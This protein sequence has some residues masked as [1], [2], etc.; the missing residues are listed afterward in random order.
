MR[1]NVGFLLL[2][3]MMIILYSM[4]FA[5]D[6]EVAENGR[7]MFIE[8]RCYTC[9]T[10]KAES[11]AI[12]KEK[13]AF[14]KSKGVELKSDDDDDEGIAPDLSDIGTKRDAESITAFLKNPKKSFKDT[15]VCKS[16]AKKKYRKRFKGSPEELDVL[17]IY[18]SSLNYDS[19]TEEDFVSCLKEE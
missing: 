16:N 2:P 1:Q 17:V 18:L 4:A 12:Q 6:N 15:P 7:K 5:Q 11:D 13:V 10:I 9:H 3:V 14:A 8:K 19:Y